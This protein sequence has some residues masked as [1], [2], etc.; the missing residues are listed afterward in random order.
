[1]SE[2][3]DGSRDASRRVMPPGAQE[4]A[5]DTAFRHAVGPEARLLVMRDVVIEHEGWMRHPGGPPLLDRSVMCVRRLA[6]A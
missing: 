5:S 2:P 1:M 3:P 4:H 6:D